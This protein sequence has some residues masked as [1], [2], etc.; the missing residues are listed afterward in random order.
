MT[1]W[2]PPDTSGSS[3]PGAGTWKAVY[4]GRN[5]TFAG[6]DGVEFEVQFHTAESLAATQRNH[7]LYNI[8]RRSDTPPAARAELQAEQRANVPLPDDL[9]TRK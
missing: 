5:D 3:S 2:K 4:A 8:S 1:T 7:D 6:P 9:P